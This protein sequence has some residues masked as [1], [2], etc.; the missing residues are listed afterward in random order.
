M[1]T[2]RLYDG[3]WISL[4]SIVAPEKGV[5]G[6]VYS[7]ETSCAGQKV[8]VM[9][10]LRRVGGNQY[11]VRREITPCWG[12]DHNLS[13]LT[14]G[15]DKGD[16]VRHTAIKEVKEESG[17]TVTDEELIPLGTAF[18]TKST[19]TIYY[20]FGVDVTNKEQGIAAGDGSPLDNDGTV[21]FEL[22]PHLVSNDPHVTVLWA[23][24][25]TKI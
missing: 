16:T 15:V 6:Y 17:Y 10:F 12:M 11:L 24:L 19:D 23:R 25:Q 20:L 8:A 4:R 14:G 5:G 3:E 7:H 22:N 21:Q 2:E 18:G 9:P 13:S 1:K